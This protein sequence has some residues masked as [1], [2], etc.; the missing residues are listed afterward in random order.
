M[1][2]S[3]SIS[4]SISLS[5]YIYIYIYI[6]IFVCRR[7]LLCLYESSPPVQVDLATLDTIGPT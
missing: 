5:L 2:I 3:I 7:R 6:Q 4:I 1:S